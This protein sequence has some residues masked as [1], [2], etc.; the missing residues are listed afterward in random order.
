MFQCQFVITEKC[1]LA[2]KYCY[3]Q[4][5][6]KIMSSEVFQKSLNFI[7]KKLKK[8]MVGGS[9]SSLL[10]FFG[11]EP[12]LNLNL[13]K[14][15]SELIRDYPKAIPTNGL[16][17]NEEV[18][19]FLDS[20]KFSVNIS[21]DGNYGNYLNRITKNGN[22]E[23]L[24]YFGDFHYDI[25]KKR[26][27]KV[28]L[29]PNLFNHLLETY[30]FFIG[31]E[32]YFPDFTLVRDDIYTE[33]D[34]HNY[35]KNLPMVTNRVIELISQGT[36]SIP[37]ILSLYILDTVFASIQGK[38]PFGCFSGTHGVGIMPNG[39][40]YPCARFGTNEKFEIADI[41]TGK[42]NYDVL[43]FFKDI[44][45]PQNFNKCKECKLYKICNAGCSYSQL[46]NGGWKEMVPIDS[47]CEL[48]KISYKESFRLYKE[49]KNNKLFI[50]YLNHKLKNSK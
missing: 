6:D 7:E 36:I 39:K 26:G 1:N 16:L 29:Y 23:S 15:N 33:S 12:L 49:L 14:D 10:A 44:H 27:C 46:E 22:K 11:G 18:F 4:N 9:S 13:I 17:L 20:N 21:F 43:K 38:R 40:I 48:L 50:D 3:M 32:I 28:M 5:R 24:R 35:E 8:E 2:C 34:I 19:S 47:V 25:M 31:K 45:N 30:D 42:I 41:V 37:G